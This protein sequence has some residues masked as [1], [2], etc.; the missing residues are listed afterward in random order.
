MHGLD[1]VIVL[2]S[3][4]GLAFPA[5]LLGAKLVQIR[6]LDVTC[7]GYGHDDVFTLDQ[8]FV[9]DFFRIIDNFRSAGNGEQPFDLF[10]FVGD[11]FADASAGLQDIQIILDLGGQF[12]QLVRVFFNAH[13]REPLEPKFKNGT[14]LDFREHVRPVVR[15]SM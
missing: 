10:E 9:F 4:S 1:D 11:D 5:A 2:G 7:F 6:A 13:R 12:F 3:H 15:D 14:R 8:I